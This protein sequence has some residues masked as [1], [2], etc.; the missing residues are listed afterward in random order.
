MLDA[1]PRTLMDEAAI[2]R[3]LERMAHEIVEKNGGTRD[4][5]LVGVVRKGDILATR[6][7]ELIE[8]I[9]GAQI[10]VGRL[11]ITLYR[12][13][14]GRS[15]A[16]SVVRRTEIPFDITGRVLVLVD[17]V[18]YTGRTTRAALDALMDYGRPKAIRYAVLL[19]RGHRELPIQPDFVGQTVVTRR[20]ERVKVLLREDGGVD[21]VCL[22]E[23][24][25][26]WIP[27]ED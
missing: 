27:G 10:P 3:T 17:D 13:D 11:D 12:D 6:L 24:A 19:D 21:Q 18:V 14:L 9:D 26:N 25:E 20:R 8:K 7:R 5:A 23:A 4:L 22:M 15:G 1:L 2:R 16:H